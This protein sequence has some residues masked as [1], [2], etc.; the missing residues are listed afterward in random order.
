MKINNPRAILSIIGMGVLTL[1]IIQSAVSG[2]SERQA[3]KKAAEELAAQPTAAPV[4]TVTISAVGD[5][6]LATDEYAGQMKSFV[7]TAEENDSSYFFKNVKKYF[8]DDDLTIVNFEGTLSNGGRREDKT[9]AFRGDPS[10]VDILTCS[11]IEAAN[12]A[13]NHSRDYGEVSNSDTH[14]I[15]SDAG[16]AAFDS[17]NTVIYEVNG[18][19]IGLIGIN[20]LNDID[21]TRLEAAM[22]DARAQNPDIIIACIHWGE[23]KATEPNEEQVAYGHKAIDLG[24]DLVLGTHPHVLQGIEQYN[25]GVI[26][27]SLGN[28]CFGGNDSPSDMDTVIYRQKFT[29]EN[30]AK[31]SEISLVPCTISSSWESGINNYQPTPAQGEKREAI[32]EKM[33]GYNTALG[34]VSVS[35]Q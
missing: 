23:E 21:R 11:G 24:A 9:F 13:N 4:R 33:N 5:C 18:L 16:L 3:E 2:I 1:A 14:K 27:Y 19:K 28:F 34:N 35:Y 10:Y 25:G 26:A 7:E 20:Q 29:L 17:L 6:T 22:A 32:I 15:L 8:T 30:G 31:R 12:L